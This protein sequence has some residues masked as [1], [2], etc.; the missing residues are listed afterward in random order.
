MSPPR[1]HRRPADGPKP[2]DAPTP[3]E[4]DSLDLER[5]LDE[6]RRGATTWP[7]AHRNIFEEAMDKLREALEEVQDTE[8]ELRRQ[9]EE[10]AAAQLEAVIARERYAE[11]FNFAPA[12][13]LVTDLEGRIL[14]ANM[15]AGALLGLTQQELFGKRLPAFVPTSERQAFRGRLAQIAAE[16]KVHEWTLR[17]KPPD[18]PAFDAA[19][20]VGVFRDADGKR[21][22]LRW[23]VQDVTERIQAQEEARRVHEVA[24][25]RYRKLQGVTD[26]LLRH[27]ELEELLRELLEAVRGAVGSDTATLLLPTPDGKNLAIRAAVGEEEGVVGEIRVPLGKGVA[28]RIA[29]ERTPRIVPDLRK[30]K[31]YSEFLR[32]KLHSLVGVPLIMDDNLVGVVHAG[33]FQSHE[34]TEE[35]VLL[36]KLVSERAAVAIVNSRLYEAEQEAREAAERAANQTAALQSVTAAL[37]E[38]L[39]IE[40]VSAIVVEKAA[41]TVGAVAGMMALLTGDGQS[42]E[43]TQAAGY[44][45]EMLQA[46]HRFPLDASLPLSEAVRTGRPVLLESVSARRQRYP[47]LESMLQ[48][49][50][51]SLAAI[52]MSIE[53]RP[54]GGLVF[55]FEDPRPFAENE[56]DFM[57]AMGRQAALA[58]ERARLYEAEQLARDQAE[59]AQVRLAFLAEAGAI[60]SRSLQMP[61]ALDSL[62]RLAV[63]FLADLCLIDVIGEEG[64]LRRMVAVHADAE[65]QPLADLLRTR[66]APDPEGPHPAVRVIQTGRSEFS[67]EMP[68]DFLRRTTRDEGHFRIVREL[69]FHSYMCVPLLSRGR[70]LGC[71][72]LVSTSPQRT[73]GPDDVELAEELA[74]RAALAVDNALLFQ[75][76]Q[77]ARRSAE[78]AAD[79]LAFLA[80]ASEVLSSSLDY[81]VL[82][83]RIA[84]LAVPRLAD[85]CLVDVL[86][87]DGSLRQLALAH[88][89]PSKEPLIRELRDRYPPEKE[90]PHPVWKVLLSGEPLLAERVTEDDLAG[91]ARDGEHLRLLLQLGIRSHIVVPLTARG[92]ILGALSFISGD[93]DRRY[94]QEDLI[95][96]EDLGRRAGIAV[97]NSQLYQAELAARRQ[98]ERDHA[99]VE[100]LSEAMASLSAA[101]PDYEATLERVAK[102][103]VPTLGDIC[104]ID[105]LEEDGSIRRI[106]VAHADPGQ[107]EPAQALRRFPPDS[108]RHNPVLTVLRTGRPIVISDVTPRIVE[109]VALNEEQL[110]MLRATRASALMIFPLIARQRTL[111]TI[112]LLSLSPH[113]AYGAEEAALAEE[114]AR[115]AALVVDNARLYERQLH[116]AR[117]LQRSLLPPSIPRIPGMELAARY[118]AAGEGNEVGGDFYDAF[119]SSDGAWILTIGDVCGKGPEAAAVTGLARHTIRAVSIHEAR[120]SRVLAM[121]NETIIRE[122]SDERFCTVCCVRLRPGPDGA[123]LTVCS[124][125]HP[126]PLILRADGRLETAGEPSMLLGVLPEVELSDHIVD[127]GPGDTIVM[128]TDGVVEEIRGSDR[129]GPDR[130]NDVLAQ[131]R[132]LSAAAVAEAVQDSL[133][134]FGPEA[135]RDDFAILVLRVKPS[136]SDPGLQNAG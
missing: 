102:L 44:P 13:H 10:L 69:G 36:L 81:E 25:T 16:G 8:E 2:G 49:P 46:W 19:V 55:R 119:E 24:V 98:A 21:A 23:I 130:L 126:L 99:R 58:L 110:A 28:G 132:G 51:H 85:W 75:G 93:T 123:R 20:T 122:L 32:R 27:L 84:T 60:L 33:T 9:N 41:A 135:Q 89:D 29:A 12:A 78:R 70:V 34:F 43:I 83:Q 129:S 71:F 61:D 66:Y 26:V 131:C 62:G 86:G 17:L 56:V 3:R 53:G 109:E 7:P 15:Q 92:R 30:A 121:L 1:G 14:E 96:A 115:R 104:V 42:L 105:V 97:D 57:V 22:E 101:V 45:Q 87:S 116:I 79:R 106:A 125:G 120:P 95:L 113:R 37:I 40:E 59:L 6:M 100:F 5:V 52:P 108:T 82:L 35:D 63:T 127:L 111:G 117:T 133:L 74:R 31:P 107:A 114:L 77:G 76:E 48:L 68:E 65:K 73:F 91:R 118:R 11:L 128:F 39:T 103:A 136:G 112:S 124:G 54:L 72:T 50:D 64:S 134:R 67:P 47:D 88:R 94:G 90:R 38:A 18:V 80:E 4:D